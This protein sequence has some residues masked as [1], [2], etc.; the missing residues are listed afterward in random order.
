[1]RPGPRTPIES[2]AV[3]DTFAGLASEWKGFAPPLCCSAR[4]RT[5]QRG[6]QAYLNSN[7]LNVIYLE[8]FFNLFHECG[9]ELSTH[10]VIGRLDNR[11]AVHVKRDVVPILVSDLLDNQTSTV[12]LCT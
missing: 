2:H 1:M 12:R 8:A 4:K 5:S 9:L 6:R 7:E 3:S 10:E 11:F